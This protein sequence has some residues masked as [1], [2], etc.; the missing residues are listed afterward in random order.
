MI[1]RVWHG[2]TTPANAPKYEVLLREEIFVGIARREIPGYRGISLLKRF[3]G[4]EVEFVTVMWFSDLHAVGLFAGAECETAVVPPKQ[5]PCYL[6]LTNDRPA[7]RQ[8]ALHRASRARNEPDHALQ[9]GRPRATIPI[10]MP[11]GRRR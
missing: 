6:D 7:M 11:P 9:R 2:W 1:T 3:V 10:A 5:V 4:D 8:S